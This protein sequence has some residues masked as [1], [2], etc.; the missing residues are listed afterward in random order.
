MFLISRSTE[1]LCILPS[2]RY[3]GQGNWSIS[4]EEGTPSMKMSKRVFYCV[5]T[6]HS[7]F[8]GSDCVWVNYSIE[9]T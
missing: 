2:V 3:L 9:V 8:K 7:L 4:D 6:V 5:S 1:M